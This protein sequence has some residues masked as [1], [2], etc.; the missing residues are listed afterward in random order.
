MKLKLRVLPAAIAGAL[1]TGMCGT[2]VAQQAAPAAKKAEEKFERIEVTG[3]RIA[4]ANLESASPITTVDAA[5]IAADGLRSVENVLNNLPSVFATQ[6][7]SISNGATGTA[8]VSLRGLGTNRTLVLVNGRRLPYGSANT[9]AADLNQIP[10]GLIKRIEILTGGAGAVYGSDAIAG[11]V[12]F[13][14]NDQFEGVQIEFNQSG[15]FHKQQNAQGVA[16]L[17]RT[18]AATNPAQFS[19]PGDKSFDGRV[20]DSSLLMG[21]NFANNKGNAT[22]FFAYKKEDALLQS[23]R[24]FSACSL[25]NLATAF[26]CGGSGTNA[27]G[28]VT[29]LAGNGLPTAVFT[30]ADSNGTSRAF[31]NALDQYNF[32]PTNFFQRPSERYTAS[33]FANYNVT[34]WAKAY[35][36]FS[37]TDYRSIAQIAP[38]GAFGTLTQVRGDNPLLSASW[39]TTLFGTATPAANAV[40]DVVI[41]RRNVEG[42][43]RASDFRNT[44]FRTLLGVKGDLGNWRYDAYMST[45]K[46]AYQQADQNYFSSTRLANA[47]DVVNVGG[48]AQC[49]SGAPCV[50]YNVWRLGGVSADQL[51]YL[52]TP[53]L[54][55][56]STQQTYQGFNIGTDLGNYGF[57]S[58]AAKNGVG[59]LIGAERRTEKLDLS[60]DGATR[61]G[62][63]SGSG[64]PTPP[65]SGK[66]TVQDIYTELRAPLIEGAA[67][68][69]LL[70]VVGSYRNSDY[71]TGKKT[72]TYG[73]GVTWQP[74]KQLTLRGSYQQTVRAPNVIELFTQAGLGLFDGNDPCAGTT[75]TAT[76]A[77]CQRTGVTAAQYG[78]IQASPAGQYNNFGGG[79]TNLNP[80][81][82]QSQTVG[83][84]FQ[85]I[86]NM[87]VS[88]DFFDIKVK[89]A[90]GTIPAQTTINQCLTNGVLCNLI[91]RDRL[92]TLWLLNDGFV[93]ANNQNL[94]SLRTA[95]YDIA[96]NYFMKLDGGWGGLRF[97]VQAT[98]LDKY[99]VENIPGRGK[100][101]CVGYWGNTC[102]SS[103]G[104]LT[105]KM[106]HKSRVTWNTPWNTDL[107]LTWRHVDSVSIDTTS[108]NPLLSDPGSTFGYDSKLGKRDYF[109][110]AFT[111][112]ATKLVTFRG[113]INNLFDKDPPLTV[114]SGPSIFGNGNTFPQVYDALGR[115]VFVSATIKF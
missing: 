87:S 11:V 6:G 16:D 9:A 89:D 63:L 52:Q 32:G 25:G 72:N 65:L 20:F 46:V 38:G 83:F 22:A 92:G 57:K 13:I 69:Q 10:A 31:N 15:Y 103:T 113:G 29:R 102:G 17:I 7:S 51:A 105:P 28:R 42:G 104:A 21:S 106:R 108:G 5:A 94:G 39:R 90:I 66:F 115:R 98:I 49:R 35:A 27:T 67:M 23:E 4:S 74:V 78:G 56:G 43:G 85:P 44:S 54:R 34:D 62:D 70:E 99:E 109:D 76:L 114:T 97:D 88:V 73:I 14:M 8:T 50:P 60:T 12:N 40:A 100:Y 41:Q 61:S 71:N 3:S 82:G 95:G 59:F 86:Q 93:R 64:G 96:F 111:W 68:A 80:E 110:V 37:F 79:N 47:L 36:E 2:A 19:V 112:A 1:A 81:K 18:R 33:V 24:D 45:S 48:V 101:D 30:T 107:S 84:I 58:P 55:T 77:Q 91:Q 53:G 75:P 26:I